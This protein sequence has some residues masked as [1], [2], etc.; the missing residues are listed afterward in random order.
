M[1]FGRIY[2]SIKEHRGWYFVE[3]Y[4]PFTEKYSR[5][6][7]VILEDRSKLK[8][9]N[10]ME[11]ELILWLQRFPVPLFVS[12]FDNTGALLDLHE[13]RPINHLI[14]FLEQNGNV[15]MHWRLLK[16]QEIPD[17]ALKKDYL[18][19]LFSNV[20][21][22][23]VVDQN[24]VKQMKRRQIKAGWIIVFIWGVL[25]PVII[26]L[27]DYYSNLVSLLA[28]IYSVFQAVRKALELMGKWPKSKKLKEKLQEEQL[29]NHYYYHC[30][31]NPEGFMRLKQENID[32]MSTDDIMREEKLI[33]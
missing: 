2:N 16:N 33:E 4:P 5:L 31:M 24:K 7:L 17:I 27:L 10:A 20:P 22:T 23:T 32:R 3:Y 29:K 18:Y 19:R 25:I 11:E 26:A 8:I 13:I 1:N 9:V 12:A 30:Q 14:G 6:N 15:S 21:Y 28:L